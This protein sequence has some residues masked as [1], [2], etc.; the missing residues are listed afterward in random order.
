MGSQGL[1]QVQK[2]AQSLVLAPQLRQSLKILQAPALELRNTILEE[3]QQNPALEE[4]P[5][6][7]ISLEQQSADGDTSTENSAEEGD[8]RL[9]DDDYSALS[10]LTEDYR[11]YFAQESG[12]SHYTADD[13]ERRQH[14][15]DSLVSETSLQEHLI[16]QAELAELSDTERAA[17]EYIVGS[18]DDRGYLTMSLQDLALMAQLP[19]NDMQRAAEIIKTLDPPGIGCADLQECL[20][21]QLRVQGK[22]GSLAARIVRECCDKLLRRRIPEIARKLGVDVD[23]VQEALADIATLDPAPGRRFGEDLNRVIEPDVTIEKD[24]DDWTIT[25]NGDYIPRLRIS[26][27]YKRMMAEGEVRGKDREYLREQIRSGKF[28]IGS[29]EQRQNT[30]KR[31]SEEILEYQ[32]G[33]FEEGVRALRPL[34]MNQIAEKVGVHE[35]TVS[36]A[37]AN[38]F[39]ETPHGVFEFKYFFTPGYQGQNGEAVSNKSVKERIAHII[40]TENSAKPYSDQEIVRLLAEEDIKIARRTVAKYREELGILPTSLRRQ[41]S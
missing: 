23:D 24:G 17:I 25:L 15:F 4:L 20:L 3:L 14:F 16:R 21:T 27:R 19:L 40:E 26:N 30:I 31:I 18:L 22:G 9:S 29:I 7:G 11:E 10:R 39:M 36:R 38:K 34:T 37:I 12:A 8:M 41:Y 32:R 1:H 33:F 13:A 5:T 2:Q 28:L 6:E 35:T